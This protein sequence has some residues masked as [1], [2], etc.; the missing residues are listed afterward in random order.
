M[1]A[2]AGPASAPQKARVLSVSPVATV[3]DTRDIYLSNAGYSVTS[4]HNTERALRL[5]EQQSFDVIIV[6]V[7]VNEDRELR[8]L[9][10]LARDRASKVVLLAGGLVRAAEDNEVQV[11]QLEGPD[12][13]LKALFD[14]LN[15]PPAK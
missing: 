7:A 14:V 9:R 5:F 4:V 12:A 8:E 6:P 15:P 1:M 3:R 11:D 10:R 2:S 13:V